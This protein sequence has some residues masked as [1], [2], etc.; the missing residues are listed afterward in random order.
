MISEIYCVFNPIVPTVGAKYWLLRNN[1][2][3]P[4]RRWV[5][6]LAL[7]DDDYFVKVY[8]LAMV[9]D[10]FLRIAWI[11]T[12]SPGSFGKPFDFVVYFG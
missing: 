9:L 5:S 12:I 4:E 10:L 7:V 1:L 11:I 6:P 2:L 3:L 8:Y